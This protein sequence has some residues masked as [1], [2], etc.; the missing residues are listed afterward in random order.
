MRFF[1]V[2]VSL[3][4]FFC[5]VASA[6]DVWPS[7][8]IRFVV[9]W[10]AG[11]AADSP[12]RLLARHLSTALGQNVIVENKLGAGGNIGTESV[13][14]AA[15]DG[16]TLLLGNVST[17]STNRF[18]YKSLPFDPIKDFAPITLTTQAPLLLAV[19][20]SVPAK[21]MAG[22]IAYAKANP[23]KLS[24]GSSGVGGSD[25]LAGE[26]LKSRTGANWVHVPYKGGPP[27]QLDLGPEDR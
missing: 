15:P 16:Y 3:L 17:I 1:K 12:A 14:K 23:G 13:A 25:H 22:L 8:P 19:N 6:E 10:P 11:G 9:P 21:D 4:V 26:L 20:P 5:S 18:L 7:R 2:V 27:A 24:F